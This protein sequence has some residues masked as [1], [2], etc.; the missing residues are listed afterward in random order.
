MADIKSIADV[1]VQKP[2]PLPLHTEFAEFLGA[3]PIKQ[4]FSI[5][6][7]GGKGSG[8]S[9]LS[10]RIA[11][12]LSRFGE[13]LYVS[14]EEST[15]TGAMRIRAKHEGVTKSNK[16]SVLET[17]DLPD[18]R[19]ALRTNAFKFC[20]IDSANVFHQEDDEVAKLLAEFPSV[21]FIVIV[22]MVKDERT[23]RG[24]FA[25]GHNLDVIIYCENKNGHRIAIKEKGRFGGDEETMKIFSSK[26]AEPL[27]LADGSK[28]V[29]G[30]LRK[31]DR[32]MMNY[33][34]RRLTG[35]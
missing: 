25:W 28:T 7:Y 5:M 12:E 30:G 6:L 2:K 26:H 29:S 34:T 15:E 17:K 31:S 3:L 22:Q 10:I 32:V 16:I 9:T 14:A 24:R 8:K 18:V 19:N 23:F 11:K 21:H 4:Q 33:H 13:F 1:L 27:Q 35:K 20:L